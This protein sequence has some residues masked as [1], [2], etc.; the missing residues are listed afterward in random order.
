MHFCVRN[1]NIKKNESEGR[2]QSDGNFANGK[3]FQGNVTIAYVIHCKLQNTVI[4]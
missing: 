3:I 4:I 1:R 2:E